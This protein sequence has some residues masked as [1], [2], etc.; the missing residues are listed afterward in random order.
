MINYYFID[1]EYE[2]HCKQLF[3]CEF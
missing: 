3:D 1:A 2:N